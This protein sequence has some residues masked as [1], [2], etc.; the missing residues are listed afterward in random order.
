MGIVTSIV[1]VLMLSL[2]VSKHH[3]ELG[4]SGHGVS[5]E[6]VSSTPSIRAH[7][8][9]HVVFCFFPIPV[10]PCALY[11]GCLW[12]SVV[13]MLVFPNHHHT[14]SVSNVT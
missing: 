3:P 7:C 5:M 4:C 11:R 10:G 8:L 2:N 6:H 12:L 13:I 1:G 14:L 9:L